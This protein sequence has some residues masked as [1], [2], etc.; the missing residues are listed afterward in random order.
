M[1]FCKCADV[2]W[3]KLAG[4]K[5]KFYVGKGL[6]SSFSVLV[7]FSV[8]SILVLFF[9]AL[10]ITEKVLAKDGLPCRQFQRKAEPEQNAFQISKL[11]KKE[12]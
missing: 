3:Q 2:G 6:F 1:A 10:H 11:L 5:N 7:Y 4:K 8:I 12:I 9:L